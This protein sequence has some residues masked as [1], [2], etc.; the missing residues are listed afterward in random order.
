MWECAVRHLCLT[1]IR[2]NG[3]CPYLLPAE[4]SHTRSLPFPLVIMVTATYLE[5]RTILRRYIVVKR[6]SIILFALAFAL[7]PFAPVTAEDFPIIFLLE[8]NKDLGRPDALAFIDGGYVDGLA[9]GMEGILT[10]PTRKK[11]KRKRWKKVKVEVHDVS[12]WGSACVIRG[13]DYADLPADIMVTVEVPS[14]GAIELYRLGQEAAAA[15]QFQTAAHY[16]EKLVTSDSLDI[17]PA[18][19]ELLAQCRATTEEPEPRKLSRKEKRA[20]K[21]KVPV[22]N[23]L[24]SYFFSHDKLEAARDY[25]ERAIRYGKKNARAKYLLCLIDEGASCGADIDTTIAIE[26]FPEMVSAAELD[27]PRLALQK[28]QTG[29]VWIAALVDKSGVVVDAK[30]SESSGVMVLDQ[31]ALRQ[32]HG[33]EYKPGIQN[34]NPISCWVTYKVEFTLGR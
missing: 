18:A 1:A 12:A 20:E 28:G 9:V 17:D 19:N 16:L 23:M 22:Y 10:R 31:A 27:Y 8:P 33:C 14:L 29:A 2:V 25:L 5:V 4:Y 34:G 15:Q 3:G 26:V 7:L 11:G 32:A 21:K 13:I 24:G 6:F 30:V